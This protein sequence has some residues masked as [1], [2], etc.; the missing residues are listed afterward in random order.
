MKIYLLTNAF[1]DEEKF[2]MTSQILR[3]SVSMCSNLAEESGRYTPA[4]QRHFYNISKGSLTEV[5]N[6]LILAADLNYLFE[7]E[8]KNLMR[9]GKEI[10]CML[11]RLI[12]SRS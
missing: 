5:M 10:E 3:P 1:P 4:D 2:G 11:V 9:D 12:H 7:E 8:T 6:L